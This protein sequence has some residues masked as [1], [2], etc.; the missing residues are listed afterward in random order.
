MLLLMLESW[1]MLLRLE[2]LL[3]HRGFT[4]IRALV[5]RTPVRLRTP[6]IAEDLNTVCHSLE[7]ACA[8]YFKR[9]MCLQRSAA[10]TLLLRRHGW[11]ARLVVGAQILPFRSHAWVE[12]DDVIINDKPYLRD[13][14][15]VLES[16]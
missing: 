7:L 16:C 14:Y 3:N 15:Q 12:I 8:F 4:A 6:Q 10:T 13:I 11:N 1:A 2:F 9:T 5:R